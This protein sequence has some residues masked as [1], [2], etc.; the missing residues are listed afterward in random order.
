M[1]KAQAKTFYNS[2]SEEEKDLI[3]EGIAEDIYFIDDEACEKVLCTLQS[4]D[5]DL[6]ERI[7]KINGFT[8]G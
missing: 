6:A 2:L 3:A 1:Q 8:R 5:H 7:R 4:T